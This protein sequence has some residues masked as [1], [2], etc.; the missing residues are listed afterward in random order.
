[1]APESSREFLEDLGCR[2]SACFAGRCGLAL[3]AKSSPAQKL[4]SAGQ[5]LAQ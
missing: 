1:M 3:P 2:E 5:A 4:R